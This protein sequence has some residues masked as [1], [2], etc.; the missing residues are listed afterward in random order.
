MGNGEQPSS[1]GRDDW[2]ILLCTMIGAALG[3]SIALFVIRPLVN[4]PL[5]LLWGT[6]AF[7][8]VFGAGILLGRL[9]GS[10]LFRRP[11]KGTDRHEPTP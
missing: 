4:P 2:R 8:A 9:A 6:L 1:G 3:G 7:A 11:Q 5:P 10:L